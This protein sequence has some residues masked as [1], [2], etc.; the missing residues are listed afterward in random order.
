[1][2]NN[3]L[4]T[5]S[6]IDQSVRDTD[7][8]PITDLSE[9]NQRLNEIIDKFNSSGQTNSETINIAQKLKDI[10][11][12]MADAL[13]V[14]STTGEIIGYNT[15]TDD[16]GNIIPLYGEDSID[17]MLN[18]LQTYYNEL[19]KN[20][21]GD[22]NEDNWKIPLNEYFNEAIT[23]FRNKIAAIFTNSSN[24]AA[25]EAKYDENN[26]YVKTDP[27]KPKTNVITRLNP[28][29][30]SYMR[31][32]NII[33]QQQYKNL[34]AFE[35]QEAESNSLVL[36]LKIQNGFLYYDLDIVLD[37]GKWYIS[38][39]TI[40]GKEINSIFKLNI[41]K[42]PISETFN[43]YVFCLYTNYPDIEAVYN[44][45]IQ[46]VFVQKYSFNNTNL[47]IENHDKYYEYILTTDATPIFSETYYVKTTD[48][49]EE[50][51][52]REIWVPHTNLT[53]FEN[54]VEYYT[55]TT[56]FTLCK[57]HD[58]IND[59]SEGIIQ[60]NTL[61]ETN[62]QVVVDKLIY[63]GS[64]C[65][66][67]VSYD[68]SEALDECANVNTELY[69]KNNPKCSIDDSV[70]IYS[71]G[72]STA[73]VVN[74]N[75]KKVDNKISCG[76]GEALF[77]MIKLKPNQIVNCNTYLNKS[78]TNV[79]VSK[80]NED[81]ESA[82]EEDF[83]NST[84]YRV[85][86]KYDILQSD[87]PDEIL[88]IDDDNENINEY[89]RKNISYVNSFT[90]FEFIDKF[91]LNEHIVV[92]PDFEEW[93]AN[94]YDNTSDIKSIITRFIRTHFYTHFITTKSLALND[95]NPGFITVP[96]FR[97]MNNTDNMYMNSQ[98]PISNN[99]HSI[100][101]NGN[102]TIATTDNDASLYYSYYGDLWH[103]LEHPIDNRGFEIDFSFC[104]VLYTGEFFIAYT[105]GEFSDIRPVW[106]Y[107]DDGINWKTTPQK[108]AELFDPGHPIF[109]YWWDNPLFDDYSNRKKCHIYKIK[110]INPDRIIVWIGDYYSY[111][112]SL[113]IITDAYH[114]RNGLES[115]E[116]FQKIGNYS[117]STHHKI[118]DVL[119]N[120]DKWILLIE[121]GST[122]FFNIAT[123][124]TT[125]NNIS[126]LIDEYP[127]N[128]TSRRRRLEF[129]SNY[130][131]HLKSWH[132]F[133]DGDYIYFTN[134]NKNFVPDTN[135][136]EYDNNIYGI[137]IS[138]LSE[139]AASGN[140]DPININAIGA[141]PRSSNNIFLRQVI[142]CSDNII[143]ENNV[144]QFKNI[145]VAITSEYKAYLSFDDTNYWAQFTLN[146]STNYEVY[147]GLLLGS[148]G[149]KIL[150]LSTSAGIISIP[151][152]NYFTNSLS[153][154]YHVANIS[155]EEGRQDIKRIC[156]CCCSEK[157][158]HN[159]TTSSHTG[160][161]YNTYILAD[162]YS[163]TMYYNNDAN[164][165]E[166][167]TLIK[168]PRSWLEAIFA[169]YNPIRNLYECDDRIVGETNLGPMGINYGYDDAYDPYRDYNLS[170]IEEKITDPKLYKQHNTNRCYMEIDET[171]EKAIIW[172][173][174]SNNR[175]YNIAGFT[176]SNYFFISNGCNDG[177]E[178]IFFT[179]EFST[180]IWYADFSLTGSNISLTHIDIPIYAT[181]MVEN[182]YGA[183]VYGFDQTF[184]RQKLYTNG[185]ANSSFVFEEALDV[186]MIDFFKAHNDEIIISTYDSED[187]NA[188]YTCNMHDG[189]E[190]ITFNHNEAMTVHDRFSFNEIIEYKGEIYFLNGSGSHP[191]VDLG[192]YKYQLSLDSNGNK[193]VVITQIATM[194][195]NYF[196]GMYGEKRIDIIP[197]VENPS[198][199]SK[200]ACLVSISGYNDMM[201]DSI[202]KILVIDIESG[203]ITDLS[204]ISGYNIP[205]SYKI[206]SEIRKDVK[207]DHP[208]KFTNLVVQHSSYHVDKINTY[209]FNNQI[210]YK[211]DEFYF[212]LK[213]KT[214]SLNNYEI[215]NDKRFVIETEKIAIGTNISEP[216]TNIVFILGQ[217]N[218]LALYDRSLLNIKV[219]KTKYVDNETRINVPFDIDKN[220]LQSVIIGNG[221]TDKQ[222]Y[223]IVQG[224]F[225]TVINNYN[226]G[227]VTFDYEN[228]EF[229]TRLYSASINHM[230][231]FDNTDEDSYFELN[232]LMTYNG[233]SSDIPS[234]R[235]DFK[236]FIRETYPS[237]HL[238][239]DLP[240]YHD[241]T[242]SSY[243][244]EY[245]GSFCNLL[246]DNT[247]SSAYWNIKKHCLQIKTKLKYHTS[248][249]KKYDENVTTYSNYGYSLNSD[250][251][252]F[253][254][255]ATLEK[256]NYLVIN[257]EYIVDIETNKIIKRRSSQ[258]SSSGGPKWGYPLNITNK[259]IISPFVD[260][261]TDASNQNDLTDQ[262]KYKNNK[263]LNR[264][265]IYDQTNNLFKLNYI[266]HMQT[267]YGVFRFLNKTYMD[268]LSRYYK[269]WSSLETWVDYSHYEEN[270]FNLM[271]MTPSIG[272]NNERYDTTNIYFT[273]EGSNSV[274]TI[275]PVNCGTIEEIYETY[276]GLF[277][278]T[279]ELKEFDGKI[280]EIHNMYRLNSIP[281]TN[282][283]STIL[284]TD[285]EYFTELDIENCTIMDFRETKY[286]IFAIG[287]EPNEMWDLPNDDSSAE[288]HGKS[289]I[290][291]YNGDDFISM[292][293]FLPSSGNSY[294]TLLVILE[295]R[296]YV[297][298]V[299]Y[300]PYGE[301]YNYRYDPDTNSFVNITYT[302][303]SLTP[304]GQA[305]YYKMDESYNGLY[306]DLIRGLLNHRKSMIYPKVDLD[307]E[308]YDDKLFC[309]NATSV[310]TNLI[311]TGTI[312]WNLE[313][314][315]FELISLYVYMESY[316]RNNLSYYIRPPLFNY[317]IN[318]NKQKEKINILLN[319]LVENGVPV[320]KNV[321]AVGSVFYKN[322]KI[323][324]NGIKIVTKQGE[325]DIPE[326]VIF[327]IDPDYRN[328]DN[329]NS[330]TKNYISDGKIKDIQD[331]DIYKANFT[332]IF[333]K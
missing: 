308:N 146:G 10:E 282:A 194:E 259:K 208:G 150:F 165:I 326:D 257:R 63:N 28:D 32:V 310:N 333:D 237:L 307:I 289:H 181:A 17:T 332:L 192:L 258:D 120:G 158:Y 156:G 239:D 46:G 187:P 26:D 188:Y 168:Q 108:T 316:G 271:D 137:S 317:L 4:P 59:P 176:P 309:W 180:G 92:L 179:S 204:T 278:Y 235:N 50:E 67:D 297:Y 225:P 279:K 242:S 83:K 97:K 273:P 113:T 238:S 206:I 315:S 15:T 329:A 105:S 151:I 246:Y 261:F 119:Y 143:N 328:D 93:V 303:E 126:R 251:Y 78:A 56:K 207:N 101:S 214:I 222:V 44:F 182:K 318:L 139:V 250:G 129:V 145:F 141:I 142:D 54:G 184:E 267:Q 162:N 35:V 74:R 95:N 203:T 102:I 301:V 190:F 96:V 296:E 201:D 313:T 140:N 331:N 319:K 3:R 224:K 40:N 49:Y 38:K 330:Y 60:N 87:D 173:N 128:D 270:G 325:N 245:L 175:K 104:D 18:K 191:E 79:L 202:E 323:L 320:D 62:D 152:N 14:D 205:Y 216:K 232:Y 293:S 244:T 234:I 132:A 160:N 312:V 71:T 272:I 298:V 324:I 215:A 198:N 61:N 6:R 254:K 186:E 136:D 275:K 80:I 211:T 23:N 106:Y 166:D 45:E 124:N 281:D 41:F 210:D 77:D 24:V 290:F 72:T 55:R 233:S 164:Y 248:L 243:V 218:A 27:I 327:N 36:N 88:K 220:T 209:N 280:I 76:Y 7:F 53:S 302:S 64:L 52:A 48:S 16:E 288:Y 169:S 121:L 161:K 212:D 34:I 39:K 30:M 134:F 29:M 171:N 117:D 286:G 159:G 177:K 213:N 122:K 115:G 193:N 5:I 314:R 266:Q 174:S 265:I 86:T 291:W 148:D 252:T 123:D 170:T 81:I 262:N 305:F 125:D 249:T 110:V 255:F 11:Y 228:S 189:D 100:V 8:I 31:S 223:V 153:W 178:Y 114:F 221:N 66:V 91:G 68:I 154:G 127:V 89:F 73:N 90:I 268:Q 84:N 322:Q 70:Q 25:M 283:S 22:P 75:V 264:F 241:T 135:T 197:N 157:S 292:Q 112:D 247:Y 200:T 321:K 287:Y 118:S 47:T 196:D 133:L 149:H 300:T 131:D 274:I 21:G 65:K 12:N 263:D 195:E 172:S 1:M 85:I 111:G 230:L 138:T 116:S 256:K 269:F 219:I 227:V 167:E 217:D 69:I 304:S 109:V 33:G 285:N 226:T 277:I 107:S 163:G 240:L 276:K 231:A 13:V 99:W 19:V 199:P 94:E 43:S 103:K 57:S 295:T 9:I 284:L 20:L 51:N 236:D 42:Y 299:S 37:N 147:E 306:T 294:R 2:G 260:T 183:F 155:F 311:P 98:E 58:L 144:E 82:N 130:T 229:E 253:D 185:K